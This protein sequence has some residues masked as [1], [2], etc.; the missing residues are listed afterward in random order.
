MRRVDDAIENGVAQVDVGR[1]HVDSRSQYARTVGELT[2]AHASEQIDALLG[3]SVAP[4]TVR[5]RLCERP[6]VLADLIGRQVIDVGLAGRDQV[7][8]PLVELLE[9]VGRIVLVLAPVEPEP[10]HIG[11]DRVDVLLLFAR[12]IRVVKPQV[13]SAAKL[14]GDAEIETDRLRVTDVEVAV[15]LGRE[16]GCHRLMSAL[17]QVGGDD[18]TDEVRAFWLG[19]R[20]CVHGREG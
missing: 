18:L 16:A 11:L 12:R 20:L 15:G 6:A 1:S 13:A 2:L 8:C 5:A 17:P 9:V 7:D 19:W 4:R 3:R 10:A 14:V